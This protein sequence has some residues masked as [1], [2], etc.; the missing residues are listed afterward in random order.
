M[1]TA[2]D[3][4]RESFRAVQHLPPWTMVQG[5][6]CR[7]RQLSCRLTTS[8]GGQAC[9]LSGCLTARQS[10]SNLQYDSYIVSAAG[11]AVAWLDLPCHPRIGHRA[12]AFQ[13]LHTHLAR[14]AHACGR[15]WGF[16]GCA[17]C[18]TAAYSRT[19][20]CNTLGFR[21]ELAVQLTLHPAYSHTHPCNTCSMLLL[22]R[23]CSWVAH[24]TKL[25]LSR[26]MAHA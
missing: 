14:K 11:L 8:M 6:L 16:P 26:H 13:G 23:V 12:L 21:V 5:M 20:P 19:C 22:M 7:C 2:T 18:V 25:Q 1:L 15:P 10:A 4:T 3:L 24:V 9:E 17:L